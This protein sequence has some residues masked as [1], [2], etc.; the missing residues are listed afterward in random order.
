MKIFTCTIFLILITSLSVHAEEK[1]YDDDKAS[2]HIT[3]PADW[4]GPIQLVRNTAFR[5]PDGLTLMIGAFP[6]DASLPENRRGI[7]D[8]L[9]GGNSEK[10]E[11]PIKPN[12]SDK[13]IRC[14]KA[15]VAAQAI[16]TYQI[17]I[18]AL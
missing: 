6:G 11:A 15:N 10:V 7:F 8:S 1:K 2:I 4:A 12:T 18:T 16:Q 14:I 9:G 3:Y 17:C 13:E 5:S